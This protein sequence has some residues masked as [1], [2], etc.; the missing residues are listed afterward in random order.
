MVQRRTNC[1]MTRVFRVEALSAN[2]IVASSSFKIEPWLSAH[3]YPYSLKRP[4][5]ARTAPTKTRM[6]PHMLQ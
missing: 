3:A 5:A 4:T 6:P 1:T 2:V